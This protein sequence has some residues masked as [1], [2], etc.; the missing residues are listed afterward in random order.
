MREIA[1]CLRYP[2]SSFADEESPALA[3]H[4]PT[5]HQIKETMQKLLHEFQPD[6]KRQPAQAALYRAWHRTWNDF[7]SDLLHCYDI[8]TLPA[9]NLGLEALFNH[10][11]RHQRRIS[12][13]KSTRELRDF[14]QYQIL[15]MAES[16]AE[17]LQQFQHVPLESYQKHRLLLAEAEKPRQFL[18]SLHRNPHETVLKLVQ[19]HNRRREDLFSVHSDP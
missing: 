14:G 7:G 13:R 11:R 18:H 6:L 4:P 10:L 5:S 8:P 16:E 3:E 19:Q 12:G 17:L 1:L 15:L 2:P 9:D